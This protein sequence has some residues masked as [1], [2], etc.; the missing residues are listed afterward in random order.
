M[1][2]KFRAWWR[3]RKFARK[4]EA[5][6]IEAGG[7]NADGATKH[8]HALRKSAADW[9]DDMIEPSDPLLELGSDMLIFV[10]SRFVAAFV[11]DRYQKLKK[12]GLVK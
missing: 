12:R 1:A 4:V 8:A 5:H 11:E 3:S 2:G 7:L 9:L 6:I 10:V